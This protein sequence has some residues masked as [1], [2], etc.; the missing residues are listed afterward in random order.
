MK[1]QIV[2]PLD[3][4]SR[5]RALSLA[6]TLKGVVWGFKVNDLLLS[7][8]VQIIRDLKPFGGVFADAK[9]HDIPNTVANGISSLAAA[10]ADL[11]TVHASGGREMLKAA[12]KHAGEAKILAVTILTSLKEADAEEMFARNIP[13]LVRSFAL[14]AAD[15]GVHG[16][17]SSPHELELLA[18]ERH[19]GS[20][21]KVT[22]GVRPAWHS[23]KDDQSRVMTPAEAT[24]L[25]ADFLVIGRPITGHE[26]PRAAAELVLEEIASSER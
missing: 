19:L 22:P 9:L 12:V 14:L 5:E 1:S 11:I 23:A 13:S 25:G 10:G 20:L 15:S 8:G 2:I 26:N 24:K 17:V 6:A 21:L 7:E 16:I 4:I 18:N 3:G